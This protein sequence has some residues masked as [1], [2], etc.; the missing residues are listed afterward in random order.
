MLNF[1]TVTLLCLLTLLGLIS[2]QLITSQSVFLY[3]LLTLFFWLLLT[4]I[5]AF[6]IRW[7]YF[8]NAYHKNSNCKSVAI[9]FDDGPNKEFTPKV[10]DILKKY[11]AKAT[12]FCIGKHVEKHPEI[13]QRIIAEGHSI[14]NHSFNHSNNW[15][16]LS[17]KEIKEEIEKTNQMMFNSVNFYPTLFRPPFGVTNPHI[18]KALEKSNLKVIGWSVRSLDTVIKNPKDI[19][20]RITQKVKQGDIILLHDTSLKSVTALEQLLLFLNDKK[21]KSITVNDLLN[22]TT[23]E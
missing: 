23:N 11:N 9:T 22:N 16:F 6:H 15:G 10:L 7:N 8:T 4:T 5:G 1:K 21:L 14:G 12:F 3:F 20:N 19:L 13:L 18:A 2:Y 17:S